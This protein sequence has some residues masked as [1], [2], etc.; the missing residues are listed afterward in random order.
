MI[1]VFLEEMPKEDLSPA[2]RAVMRTTTY[3]K[4]PVDE[5]GAEEAG[6]DAEE[7][8][9]GADPAADGASEKSRL[10]GDCSDSRTLM[11]CSERG[12]TL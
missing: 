8:A 7:V 9:L 12:S 6:W 3:I 5:D 4:W 10:V 2:M 11:L 1:L